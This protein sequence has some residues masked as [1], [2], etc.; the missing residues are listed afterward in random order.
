MQSYEWNQNLN[1]KYSSCQQGS[2]PWYKV[3]DWSTAQNLSLK[4]FG[5]ELKTIPSKIIVCQQTVLFAICKYILVMWYLTSQ[6][7]YCGTLS[8]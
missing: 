8:Q 7:D 2:L 4:E 3:H 5:P 1:I 6:H